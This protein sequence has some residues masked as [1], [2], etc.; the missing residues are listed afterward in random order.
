MIGNSDGYKFFTGLHAV[1]HVVE[2]A[3]SSGVFAKF[4]RNPNTCGDSSTATGSMIA[5]NSAPD[6]GD[7]SDEDWA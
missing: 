3:V 6:R 1:S 4:D 5:N 7:A 2:Y